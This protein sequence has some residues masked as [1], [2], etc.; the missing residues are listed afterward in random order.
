MAISKRANS[1]TFADE[2]N[3]ADTMPL[4]MPLK[5][6]TKKAKLLFEESYLTNIPS[7]EMY[8]R[9]YMHRDIVTHVVVAAET[10]FIITASKDGHVK[11][12]KKMLHGIEFVKHYKAHMNE[13][14]G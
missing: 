8:E 6:K 5:R 7:A 13:I 4:P 1:D 10:Q 12:W 3:D 9:S 2:E 14:L 11:F